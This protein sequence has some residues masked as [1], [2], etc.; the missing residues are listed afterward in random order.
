MAAALVAGPGLA[1][2]ATAGG[3]AAAGSATAVRVRASVSQ[4][5]NPAQ[6]RLSITRD[7]QSYYDEPIRS[8][9]CGADCM[10]TGV[11][12]PSPVQVADLEGNGQPDVV[13]GLYTGGAH[14]C[15]VD[16]VFSYDPGTMTYGRYE[17][18][19]LDA[20]A[21]IRRI[22][23]HLV[24]LSADAR[25]AD[26]GLTDFA[27]AGAPIQIW[28]FAHHRFTDITREFPSRIRADAARWSTDAAHDR[29]NDVGFIAAWAADEDL[30]GQE[31]LVS[32]TL[33]ADAGAH[34]LHTP[35]GLPHGSQTAFV[36]ELQRLLRRL[37]YA[38]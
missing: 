33:A 3:G 10:V 38:R 7:G 32:S 8:R 21:A 4:A 20:G 18:D 2:A 6:A 1:A 36:A 15:F 23:G 27:D 26:A 28:R 29:G 34:R 19:F 37:G 24:F 35:L 31:A 25:L 22:G 13:L 12:G 17:H 9:F 5:S 11:S 14:C 30:L 16:Q